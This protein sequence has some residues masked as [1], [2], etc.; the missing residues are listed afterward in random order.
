MRLSSPVGTPKLQLAAEQSSIG[1]CWSPPKKGTPHPR[2]KEKPQQ[3]DRRGKIAFRIKPLT[4]QRCLGG[5]NKP[6]APGDLTETEPDLPLNVWVSP[7]AVWFSSG[8]PWGQGLWVQQTWAWH[9]PSWR[10]SHLIP[11]QSHQNL[12]RTRETDSWRA[13]TKPGAHQD[14]LTQTCLWV[15]VHESLVE[16]WVVSGLLQVQRHWVRQCVHRTFW[17]RSPLSSLP[18]P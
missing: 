10:R 6:C 3:D 16:V 9:K 11:L 17:R 1:E 13:Q 4:H 18:P 5:P 14:Q 12:H 7:A 8:L 15:S 2:A